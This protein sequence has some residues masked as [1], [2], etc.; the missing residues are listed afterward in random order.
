MFV[1]RESNAEGRFCAI[2]EYRYARVFVV[3]EEGLDF[4]LRVVQTETLAVV[5][6]EFA[7]PLDERPHFLRIKFLDAQDIIFEM[8]GEVKGGGIIRT[9]VLDDEDAIFVVELAE[10]ESVLVVVDAQHIG[11]EP[12][13]TSAEG[14]MS[15]LLEGN[16]FDFEFRQYIASCRTRFDRQLG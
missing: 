9:I 10:V 14:R 6:F 16:R 13:L 3:A 4:G 11:I 15:F 12:D 1:V 7:I 2:G 8:G 5:V